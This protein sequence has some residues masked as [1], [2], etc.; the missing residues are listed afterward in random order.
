MS[1]VEPNPSDA[2]RAT[3]QQPLHRL[4]TLRSA[5]TASREAREAFLEELTRSCRA[6]GGVFWLVDGGPTDGSA[7]RDA[8]QI[9]AEHVRGLQELRALADQQLVQTCGR[10]AI[11]T[12]ALGRPELFHQ[13]NVTALP[14]GF[15]LLIVPLLSGRVPFGAVQLF[16]QHVEEADRAVLLQLVAPLVRDDKLPAG[17]EGVAVHAPESSGRNGSGNGSAAVQRTSA[18]LVAESSEVP[19]GHRLDEFLLELH[20]TL[21]LGHV[22]LT[23]V[24]DGRQLLGCDRVSLA[25]RRGGGWEIAAISG[26]DRVNRRADAT[27][28][29]LNLA[30]KAVR[31]PQPTL[32]TGDADRLPPQLERPLA[33]YVHHSG[34]RMIRLMPLARPDV[35]LHA[36]DDDQP[37]RR[38]TA[39]IGCLILESFSDSQLSEA[40]Q[41]RADE[42]APHV[43]TALNNSMSL[44]QVPAVGLWRMLGGIAEW[45]H[46]RRLTKL[47][48]TVAVVASLIGA[49][50]FVPYDYRLT[51][52]G[53]L[54]PVQRQRVFAPWDGD[55]VQLFV[56]SGQHVLAGAPLAQLENEELR[57]QL[58]AARNELEEKQQ[59]QLSLQAQIDA[60]HRDGRTEEE[61]RLRGQ[62]LETR[63]QIA[64]LTEQVS[65]LQTRYDRL[66]VVAPRDGIVATFQLEQLLQDRPVT[67]GE[68]LLE[69]MQERGPWE[70]EVEIPD[71]RMGHLLTFLQSSPQ[72]S[73]E[74]EFV[75]QTDTETAFSGRLTREDL[76]TRSRLD[77][78]GKA[79]VEARI[80]LP[81]NT[82]PRRRIGAAVTAKIDCGPMNLGYV[83]FGD[84]VEFLRR[85]LWL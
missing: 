58:V 44:R 75:L 72:K 45:L 14:V 47:V 74:V 23:V 57:Q 34:A 18:S 6:R 69:I 70:L 29:L 77:Q 38:R 55:V 43:A 54:L 28:F 81:E 37:R 32:F 78:D 83:L 35:S 76:G 80:A 65:I 63:T 49:L 8:I 7:R 79:V 46:G 2:G 39:M 85:H 41:T 11:Q 59:Q 52:E 19:S 1:N 24:N 13:P 4:Q 42:F 50:T 36:W 51:A 31:T 16:L 27:R 21:H 56:E 3:E 61:T 33:D 60:A 25:V 12:L 48:L 71:Y 9:R 30:K 67:R 40:V 62:L 26:I 64:G 68:Q 17:R 82:P 10:L 84:V 15:S 20:R 22:A 5:C 66:R 73:V 53:R